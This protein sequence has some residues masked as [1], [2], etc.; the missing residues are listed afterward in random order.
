MGFSGLELRLFR[1]GKVDGCA[2]VVDLTI[3]SR[4]LAFEVHLDC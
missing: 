3:A 1:D 2:G 4:M